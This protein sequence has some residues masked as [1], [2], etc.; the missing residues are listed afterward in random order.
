M[1]KLM[2]TVCL[3]GAMA[4]HAQAETIEMVNT[5]NTFT[6]TEKGKVTIGTN[7]NP[8]TAVYAKGPTSGDVQMLSHFVGTYNLGGGGFIAYHNNVDAVTN[9]ETLPKKEDRL[10][11][12][13]FGS[14]N[15]GSPLNSAGVEAHAEGDWSVSAEGKNLPTYLSFQ[16]TGLPPYPTPADWPFTRT[17]R[18]R[19][20]AAGN[21]GIGTNS[22]TQKLEVDGGVRLIPQSADRSDCNEDTR[23]TFWVVRDDVNGDSVKVCVKVK[24]AAGEMI[25]ETITL[26]RSN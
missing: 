11:Y 12:L 5:S 15:N 18:M 1:K 24:S 20:T 3:V 2:S 14:R 9:Q 22:P 17:E 16:T 10:G 23:G 7:V 8:W 19:I 21:V 13:L 6:V 25:W 26:N 4:L